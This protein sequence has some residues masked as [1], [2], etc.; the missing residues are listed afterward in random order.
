VKKR[1]ATRLENLAINAPR[2]WGRPFRRWAWR[3]IGARR[4]ER[5]RAAY[6]HLHYLPEQPP[7]EV[8]PFPL[9]REGEE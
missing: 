7:G 9:D 3:R 2:R 4:M 1:D 8:I 6:P 5:S